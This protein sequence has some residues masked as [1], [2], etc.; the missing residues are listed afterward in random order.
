MKNANTNTIDS[1]ITLRNYERELQLCKEAGGDVER[2]R[3]LGFDVYQL[4]QILL[5]LEH[6]IDTESYTNPE[7]SWMEME[8]I[9]NNLETG[10]DMSK[11]M[12]Q[13]FDGQQCAEI[14]EGIQAKLDVSIYAKRHFLAPQMREI[15]KGMEKGLDVSRYASA[16]YDW[17]QMKEIRRGL[18]AGQ[19]VA[20]YAKPKY[21]FQTM[22]AIRKALEKNINLISYAEQGVQGKELL[23]LSRGLLAGNDIR[24]FLEKGYDAGQ[25][26]Q[27]N[28]AYE[29]GVNLIPYLSYEFQGAQLEQ[30]VKGLIK[31][32]DI[33][34]YAD[35]RYNWLQMREI[36][37]GMEDKADVSLYLNPDFTAPQ[38]AEIR[39]G[40]LAG[41]E[42]EK[43]AKIYLEPEQMEQIRKKLEE[44]EAEVGE[45][46]KALYASLE[47]EK[48]G[49]EAEA[50]KEAAQEAASEV[51]DEPDEADE[52]EKGGAY[53]TISDDRM[54]AMVCLPERP[55]GEEYSMADI[56]RLL[57]HADVK[58][59]IDKMRIKEMLEQ[60]IY[61]KEVLV[62][63]GKPPVDGKD[64]SFL[65]YFRREL[66][67]KPK[68]L[69][70]GNVDYKS[71]ELFEEVKANQLLVEYQSPT[72]GNFG[73]DVMGN[74]LTPK[75]GRE[76]P[77]LHGEGFHM[78]DDR[79][80]YYA[81]INGIAECTS[82]G[83][84]EVRSIYTVPGNVD[85]STGNV[86]FKGD[87]NVMGN[88]EDGFSI[89]AT[90][91]VVIDG[92]CGNCKI[93]AGKD[94][95]IRKGCQGQGEGE[96]HAGGTITGK[97][98]ESMKLTAG[99][100][101]VASYLLNCD[102]RTAGK[103]VV[104]GRRGI[105][106]GGYTCA[107]QGIDCYGIGNVAE[108]K[109]VIEVGIDTEDI[110]KYQDMMKQIN[111]L[112]SEITTMEGATIKL[113]KIKEKD[114]KTTTMYNRLTKALYT[115]KSQRKELL[116]QREE[117]ME[118]M[119][120]QRDARISVTGLVY[121]GVRLFINSE[122][123]VVSEEYR[124]VQFTKKEG[125]VNLASK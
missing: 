114:E 29:A 83:R 99:E 44:S 108:T 101:I 92:Q 10:I 6:G 16:D 124:N 40:I 60:K 20:Q 106:I 82:E 54:R 81:A 19:N 112:E 35:Q 79:K 12:E 117:K 95:L 45:D 109:T 103:L 51:Q 85:L 39:K 59:G 48:A 8:A 102:V 118:Q 55:E 33:S 113:M 93:Q 122:P 90:G 57:R 34:L 30:M 100:R 21:K 2:Y 37:Y 14:R 78:T 13:G 98:F 111:K 22:R 104:E 87:V 88:V 53:V 70:N 123:F 56:Q 76:L 80:Q 18:E 28:A 31:E 11:Y 74:I 24:G 107:K 50:K 3:R 43:Y 61:F 38:M 58:Q 52:A 86:I 116:K 125:K 1:E 23:E 69:K 64:G 25:L 77:P 115:V 121:P 42:A 32:L 96:L 91:N 63:E 27:I 47:K 75:R 73:Y 46:M 4:E 89:E 36:R 65:Y 26:A 119:E 71:M 17:L 105:I 68:V 84:L 110:L 94:I 66:K 62:A 120:K 72:A 49:E 7:L 9:R 15:R 67:R 97:F 5:G 41:V